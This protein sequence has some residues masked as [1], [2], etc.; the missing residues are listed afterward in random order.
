[1]ELF[2]GCLELFGADQSSLNSLEQFAAFRRSLEL[3]RAA[4]TV[5]SCL[6]QLK[7]FGAVWSC[8]G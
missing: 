5:W 4:Q 6:E 7:Q 8:S 3:F 2:R 1:L